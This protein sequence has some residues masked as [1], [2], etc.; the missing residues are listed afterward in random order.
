MDNAKLKKKNTKTE[1]KLTSVLEDRGA[2]NDGERAAASSAGA[3]SAR[4]SQSASAA[5]TL[6]QLTQ[7][8]ETGE[9]QLSGGPNEAPTEME[10]Q[11]AQYRE[12]IDKY[13]TELRQLKKSQQS[14]LGEKEKLITKLQQFES[15]STVYCSGCK[16]EL[17]FASERD[18]S[19]NNNGSDDSAESAQ[20]HTE[21]ELDGV[22]VQSAASV[23]VAGNL[24]KQSEKGGRDSLLSSK[25]RNHLEGLQMLAEENNE[26]KIQIQQ[27]IKNANH[28]K[29]M[30]EEY[31][32][33]V[34]EEL[35][36][37]NQ[38]KNIMTLTQQTFKSSLFQTG[39]NQEMQKLI[40]QLTLVVTERDEQLSME[41]TLSR[42]LRE[43]LDEA[44][45][46]L[47]GGPAK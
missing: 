1:K 20:T 17:L 11:L 5:P 38:Y 8:D 24:P 13:Q 31:K 27:Q 35:Q 40:G 26:M 34:D 30:M 39:N 3:A 6:S 42:Q 33:V 37:S 18:R 41:R 25:E 4:L 16:V 9:S 45:R 12:E 21:K 28:Y 29:F 43:S 44:A 10:T 15:Q 22:S 23:S 7:T 32:H 36:K 19:P 47:P 14:F 46:Q 2:G